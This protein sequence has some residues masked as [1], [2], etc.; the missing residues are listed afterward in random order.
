MHLGG[1]GEIA[2]AGVGEVGRAAKKILLYAEHVRAIIQV[3]LMHALVFVQRGLGLIL[4]AI[5]VK[6]SL[7]ALRQCLGLHLAIRVVSCRREHSE[8]DESKQGGPLHPVA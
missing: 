3:R 7:L 4:L 8:H 5:L 2:V 6:F 1:V